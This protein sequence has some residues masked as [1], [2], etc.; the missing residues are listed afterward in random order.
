MRSDFSLKYKNSSITS[1]TADSY[2]IYIELFNS[3]GIEL[4]KL[5]KSYE[6]ECG[7]LFLEYCIVLYC[8]VPVTKNCCNTV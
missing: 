7:Y 1:G 3:T 6:I 2:S 8:T 5:F 4:L